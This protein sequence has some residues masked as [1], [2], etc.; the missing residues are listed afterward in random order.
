MSVIADN[1]KRVL[2]RIGAA[3]ERAGRRPDDIQLIV[4]TKGRSVA[5]IEEAM[6][7]GATVIGENRVQE[8][9]EKYDRL[10]GKVSMHMIGHLQRNKVR[11][12]LR[13]FSMIHSVDSLRLVE[14]LEREAA[15][16]EKVVPIL[17]EVN[18]S[19][20]STKYG[21]SP[22]ELKT[23]VEQIA[24]MSY[25]QVEGLMTMTPIT[26]N[27]EGVRPLFRQVREIAELIGRAAMPG[28]RMRHLSMGMSHDFEAAVEEGATM[29]R[30][31]TA[32]FGR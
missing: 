3:A 14:A 24:D 26:D 19:G 20:E 28:V 17:I 32:I 6:R 21:L 23:V 27:P 11:E 22:A 25:I 7:A 1:L 9:R 12:A 8:A 29:V 13:I 2:E 15:R 16:A 31:G 18:V 5:E 30:I 10:G 4:S